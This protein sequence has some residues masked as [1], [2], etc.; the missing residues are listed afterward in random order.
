MYQPASV[1]EKGTLYQLKERFDHK[2]IKKDVK[3]SVHASR[4][5]IRF[6][7]YG[8]VVIAAMKI[9]GIHDKDD[10]P[11]VIEEV[12]GGEGRDDFI[13]K[14][15]NEIVNTFLIADE[16][17]AHNKQVFSNEKDNFESVHDG[18]EKKNSIQWFK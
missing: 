7:S 12:R 8:Y 16:D 9:L 2:N 10:S 11:L 14:P 15:A 18:C 3:E 6:A 1:A 5:L 13:E 17:G 4:E